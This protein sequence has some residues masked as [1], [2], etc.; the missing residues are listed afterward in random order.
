MAVPVGP[1]GSTHQLV[2][3]VTKMFPT[4]GYINNEIFFQKK[5]VIGPMV[6]VGD[7][8]AA[9]A[10]YQPNMPIKWSAEKVWVVQD[11]SG[12]RPRERNDEEKYW[13]DKSPRRLSPLGDRRS[14]DSNHGTK[15]DRHDS[16]QSAKKH[17][18]HRENDRSSSR[19]AVRRSEDRIDSKRRRISPVG[20]I[21]KHVASSSPDKSVASRTDAKYP[22]NVRELLAIDLSQRFTMVS[23]PVD[24]YRVICHWQNSFPLLN[25]LQ[26]NRSTVFQILGRAEDASESPIPQCK[27][28]D[29]IFVNVLLLAIP[30]M[31]VLQDKTVVRAESSDHSRGSVRKYVK[32][33][34]AGRAKERF[35]A[36]GGQWNQELDGQDPNTNPQVLINTAIRSCK[37]QIGLDLS[38]CKH[39]HRFLEF[40]Y[41]RTEGSTAR[42][43]TVLFPGSQLW[44]Q[45][46]IEPGNDTAP[47]GKP[48]HR[49]VVYFLPD[50][51]SLMPST[52]DWPNVKK[53]FERV[54]S[55][56]GPHIFPLSPQEVKLQLQCEQGQREGVIS[57]GTGDGNL[58]KS[59]LGSGSSTSG[60]DAKPTER[61]SSVEPPAT[62]C[63]TETKLVSST[64]AHSD[65]TNTVEARGAQDTVVGSPNAS[66]IL[67]DQEDVGS[68][69]V[70]KS[71]DELNLSSMKV[72]ELREQLKA[73]NLPADGIKAQLLSRLKAAVDKEAE[74]ARKMEEERKRKEKEDQEA[75]ANRTAE[76]SKKEA[77]ALKQELAAASESKPKESKIVLRNYPSIVVQQKRSV[78]YNLQLV[79]LDTILESK[80]DSM[81]AQSYEFM[82]CAQN[83][84]DML[85]RDAIFILFRALVT[86]GDRGVQ[87]KA[88]SR[89]ETSTDPKR[90]RLD[91]KSAHEKGIIKEPSL[92]TVDLPLLYACTLLDPSVRGYFHSS[93]VEELLSHLGLPISR[94]QLRSL[95]SK[96]T[97]RNRIYYRTLTDAESTSAAVRTTAAFS[98]IDDDEYLLELIRGG[99]AILDEQKDVSTPP[100]S[101][102]VFRVEGGES[103]ST[104]KAEDSTGLAPPTSADFIR[105]LKHSEME[106]QKLT[107]T[108]QKRKQEIAKLRTLADKVPVLE[109]KLTSANASIDDYRKRL[110]TERDRIH[111]VNRILEQEA[112]SL[113]SSRQSLR[114]AANRLRG[115]ETP[116][117]SLSP[118]K[119]KE[120]AKSQPQSRGVSKESGQNRERSVKSTENQAETPK[121]KES[122]I[123]HEQPTNEKSNEISRA[124]TTVTPPCAENHLPGDASTKLMNGSDSP[125]TPAEMAI[126]DTDSEMKASS[127]TEETKNTTAPEN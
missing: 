88:R 54:L 65:R 34:A 14:R 57:S 47:P 125:S 108:L 13:P 116:K 23:P 61:P 91:S 12:S 58:E 81:D 10:I 42:P 82:F 112:K 90:S 100:E 17:E 53:S 121:S 30:S 44:G 55:G 60:A 114:Q 98:D 21:R 6:E 115:Q 110:K 80:S 8:V 48:F 111:S 96:V 43:V 99:D 35:K 31:S 62:P 107:V 87:A 127:V 104:P 102:L 45:S 106:C 92:H 70:L 1:E 52:D 71:H 75:Q 56:K 94:Y 109:G 41:S 83:L 89:V 11:S 24:L 28:D 46:H 69:K 117:K 79:G 2:G 126:T 72:S 123:S 33:L 3:Y 124:P 119:S 76:E 32:V 63:G 66:S 26:P 36:I 59:K 15:R 51:W 38:F 85:R 103:S 77:E 74:E 97:D 68:S 19:G 101:I 29:G 118:S 16:G 120:A 4:F 105:Q 86:A 93:D 18:L 5:C 27:G 7:N 64:P 39:W 25:P 37:E 73:R 113:E 122:D 67:T 49:I 20:S 78:D 40:R 9:S 95:V 50:I 84:L 22:L